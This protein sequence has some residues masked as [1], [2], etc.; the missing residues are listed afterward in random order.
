MRKF[1]LLFAL[2]CTIACAAA[3]GGEDEA[4]TV[5]PSAH[6]FDDD[7]CAACGMIV[8]EQPS[9]RGQVVH[10]DG[11]RAFFCSIADMH[12]Y[13]EAPSPHGAVVATHVEV[14]AVDDDPAA[15]STAPERWVNAEEAAYVLG[16]P[17]RMIMGEPVL[18]YASHEDAERAA[19]RLGGR[20]MNWT[21]LR[22]DLRAAAAREE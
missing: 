18:V 4:V 10:R 7:E 17:R 13:L 1:A 19:E 12:S 8:R 22:S 5:D 16:V 6:A 11:E 15:R 21:T 14:L 2:S 9:P 3:C 20:T